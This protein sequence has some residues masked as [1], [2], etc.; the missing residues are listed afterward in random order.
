MNINRIKNSSHP[1]NLFTPPQGCCS[2]A[3]ATGPGCWPAGQMFPR[4]NLIGRRLQA[5]HWKEGG[6]TGHRPRATWTQK[7]AS[8]TTSCFVWKTESSSVLLGRAAQETRRRYSRDIF[9]FERSRDLKSLRGCKWSSQKAVTSSF[10][11]EG[12]RRV[13][14]ENIY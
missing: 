13:F 14:G 2:Q 11:S 3:R 1:P 5:L 8:N 12:L 7:Q 4:V 10:F 9:C 6:R